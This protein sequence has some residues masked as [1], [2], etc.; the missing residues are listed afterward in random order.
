MSSEEEQSSTLPFYTNCISD[1]LLRLVYEDLHLNKFSNLE[2]QIIKRKP[3][4]V[5][6]SCTD[7]LKNF[8]IVLSNDDSSFQLT[9][10]DELLQFLSSKRIFVCYLA[11]ASTDGNVT[12]LNVERKFGGNVH[13][14][15]LSNFVS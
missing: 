8:C 14:L 3:C 10:L 4:F 7:V 12:Y 2:Y 11:C 1:V 13:P 9:E 15:V 6:E 5:N